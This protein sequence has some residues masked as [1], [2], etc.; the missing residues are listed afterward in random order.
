MALATYYRRTATAASQVIGVASERRFIKA[1]KESSVGIRFG[2]VDNLRAEGGHLADFL[3]RL[4]A[5][6]Y[7][8]LF[9]TGGRGT[10]GVLG[11]LCDLARDINPGID[12][13]EGSSPSATVVVGDPTY[14]SGEGIF[15]VTSQSWLAHLSRR[16]IPA[17][18]PSRNPLGAAAAACLAAAA[19]FNRAFIGQTGDDDV[20]VSTWL[21]NARGASRGAGAPELSSFML[22]PRTVIVGLGGVGNAL[23]WTLS[24]LPATGEV[25]LVDPEAVDLGNL[26]RY[27]LARRKDVG[28][29]KTNLAASA[30]RS[31]DIRAHRSA[32]DWDAFV[33]NNGY[34]WDDVAV[35]VDS[36]AGRRHVQASLPAWIA[37]AWTQAT[38]VGV[39]VHPDF[40]GQG[41]CLSCLYVRDAESPSDDVRIAK[42]L[43][44]ESRVLEVR[45][46]LVTNEGISADLLAQIAAHF[47]VDARQLDPFV[48][49]PLRRFYSE[50]ICGH[51]VLPV[52]SPLAPEPAEEHVPLAHQSAL[53]GVLLASELV[54]RRL[55]A[56]GR[57][58]RITRADV[59]RQPLWV[60]THPVRAR[61]DGLCFCGDSDYKS[62][63]HRKYSM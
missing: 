11:E 37:N 26:Q 8:R 54:A 12:V 59:A 3:V 31:T 49:A 42:A 22:A 56:P 23:I 16:N 32:T 60:Q 15:Y 41:A 7:P 43:G 34:D 39:S 25:W 14:P 17:P 29:K 53:A 4:F 48:G 18:G 44:L 20:T 62:A 57:E 10:D 27:V 28:R 19:V 6:V 47:R 46:L 30:L 38:E 13:S 24:R 55:G 21:A 5:R 9:L 61:T 52:G 63:Y 58:A 45:K 2:A 1:L 50:G 35:S 51:A 33:A 40:G 36:A